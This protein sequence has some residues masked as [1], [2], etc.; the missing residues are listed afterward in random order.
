MNITKDGKSTE[1]TD[2]RSELEKVNRFAKTALTE[3][4]VFTFSVLLCD[5]E[6]DRDFERF[7][8]EALEQLREL[9]VGKTGICDHEWASG[10]QKARIYRTELV[11]DPARKTESGTNYM[12]L[13]GYAYMLRTEANAELIAEING[14]IKKETSVG[15]AVRESRCSICGEP[16]GSGACVHEKGRKY[17]GRLCFAELSDAS[18]AYEWSFVAVPAQRN[19][20]VIKR[21]EHCGSLSELAEKGG[22]SHELKRLSALAELGEK[23]IGQLRQEV[24][25]LG[26]VCGGETY[27]ALKEPTKRMSE[28]ELNALHKVL[29]KRARELFPP[30]VQLPLG[31][32]TP[33]F[34]G[35]NYKI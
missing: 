7:S 11:T 24:L 26:L 35:G 9:F 14:G 6:V 25:R 10:N 17:D 23:Y 5:N 30:A 28:T 13:K 16:M 4:E 21:F 33:D 34:D 15:C 32:R 18:D 27:D 3:D 22:L 20:G 2:T 29:E 31:R 12:Y 1:R 19:A 8:E